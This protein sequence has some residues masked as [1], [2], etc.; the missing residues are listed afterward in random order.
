MRRIVNNM[1]WSPT[2]SAT[3][4]PQTCGCKGSGPAV[5]IDR[6][7]HTSLSRARHAHVGGFAGS[8]VWVAL[9]RLVGARVAFF[10]CL[11]TDSFSA[12]CRNREEHS[13]L[14]IH[15]AEFVHVL[16][17]LAAGL[18]LCYGESYNLTWLD[19]TMLLT[20]KILM[21][22]NGLTSFCLV[23]GVGLHLQL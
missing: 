2:S 12:R 3:C 20:S 22:L 1:R 13:P 4:G 6:V 15:S 5:L 8:G 17:L 11:D 10:G 19:L 9:Q 18:A 16:V 23:V 14:A 7:L 21:Y